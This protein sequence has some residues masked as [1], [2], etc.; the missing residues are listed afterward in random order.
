MD[1][2]HNAVKV[3]PGKSLRCIR[4]IRFYAKISPFLSEGI[5]E[6]SDIFR[7]QKLRTCTYVPIVT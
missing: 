5:L 4:K 2:E 7:C 1:P 3:R 6:T